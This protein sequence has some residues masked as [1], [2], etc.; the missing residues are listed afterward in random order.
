MLSFLFLTASAKSTLSGFFRGFAA[1][2]VDDERGQDVVEYL[3]VLAVVAALIGV[4]IG[5]ANGLGGD[6]TSGASHVISEVFN[7]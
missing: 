3:G 7:H 1:R 5:V 2:I 6:I 4:V